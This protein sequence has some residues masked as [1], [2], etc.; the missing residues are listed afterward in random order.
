MPGFFIVVPVIG[1]VS[2][3]ADLDLMSFD[4]SNISRTTIWIVM[5]DLV[6]ENVWILENIV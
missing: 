2:L 3:G 6:V 4:Y 1:S 5:I